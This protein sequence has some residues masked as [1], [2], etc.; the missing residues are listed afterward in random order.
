MDALTLVL[1]VFSAQPQELSNRDYHDRLMTL[2]EASVKVHRPSY[3]VSF[4]SAKYIYVSILG[5]GGMQGNKCVR[6][7]EM[8]STIQHTH[9]FLHCRISPLFYM[10]KPTI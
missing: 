1:N 5:S 2:L 3:H 4:Y 6:K 9:L 7:R 10:S 8:F